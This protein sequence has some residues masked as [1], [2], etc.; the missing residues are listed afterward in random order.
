MWWKVTR[1][2]AGK[3]LFKSIV[4]EGKLWAESQPMRMGGRRSSGRGTVNVKVKPNVFEKQ[5][6]QVCGVSSVI[7][8]MVR[9][10]IS[11]GTH[12]EWRWWYDL[13]L[14]EKSTVGLSLF[15]LVVKSST[16]LGFNKTWI[17]VWASLTTRAVTLYTELN[18][19]L[20]AFI[21]KMGMI[22]E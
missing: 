22:T 12:W 6:G 8:S 20:I 15:T 21:G 10:K 19:I 4:Q 5:E 3:N 13:K 1:A 9:H 17:P 7:G 16:G 18:L 14:L 2:G 11:R